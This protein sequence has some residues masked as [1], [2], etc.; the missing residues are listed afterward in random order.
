EIFRLQEQESLLV[1]A[2][3]AA[4]GATLDLLDV[5]E[6]AGPFGTGHAAPLFAL[7]RHRL[8]DVR[9]AGTNHLRADLA[10][11]SGGRIQAMAFR[12]MD[13]PLGDFLLRSRGSMVHV[14][15]SLSANYW[16]G[17][18][19][20]QFRVVDAAEAW[21]GYDL[22]GANADPATASELAISR[23]PPV[24]AAKGFSLLP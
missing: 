9:L 3:L 20:M 18:R 12:S 1:D 21:S 15:G 6:K 19:R 23:V 2:A 5:L 17:T 14:V 8:L 16:N 24:G 13:T 10:S 22:A 7:P 11:E 4:E